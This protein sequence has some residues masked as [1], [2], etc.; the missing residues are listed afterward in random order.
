MSYDTPALARLAPV[1]ID[2]LNVDQSV[3]YKTIVDCVQAGEPG[4]FFVSRYGGT[5]KTYLWNA[6]CAFLRGEKKLF[7]PSHRRA[8]R[9]Y[10]CLEGG[11]L[12]RASKYQ[13]I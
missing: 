5:G 8:S 13:L 3:A 12:I 10:C 2:S 11:L 9:P 6:I 1:L 7:S 4:F